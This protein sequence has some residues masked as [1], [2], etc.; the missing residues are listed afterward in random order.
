M[1]WDI[2]DDDSGPFRGFDE[3]GLGAT[4][5]DDSK[6]C[7]PGLFNLGTHRVMGEEDG[8]VE[9]RCPLSRVCLDVQGRAGAV[10]LADHDLYRHLCSPVRF[11]VFVELDHVSSSIVASVFDQLFWHW[12]HETGG[13]DVVVF[14]LRG[15][16]LWFRGGGYLRKG[17]LFGVFQ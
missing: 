5:C 8:K 12:C 1:G 11:L 17:D 9:C 3:D 10:D 6:N 7:V 15:G 4:P 16:D 13:Q 2:T 14:W